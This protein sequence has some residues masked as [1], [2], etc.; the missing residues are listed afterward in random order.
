MRI[1]TKETPSPDELSRWLA[2]SEG[3]LQGLTDVDEKPTRLTGYQL[4]HLRDA[5]KFRAREKAR[6]VGFSFVC[7]AEALAKAHLRRDY[8]AIFV[9]MNLEEAVEKIRYANQLYHSLPLKWQKKKVVDNKTSIEFEDPSGRYRSRLISH[10]CKDPR[11]KHKADVFL[12]EFAHYGHKQ[13]AIYVAAV[14]IVSRGDGQLT[15]GSTPLMVGDLFHEIMKEERRKYPMFT[16]Q[17]VPWWVCPEFCTNVARAKAQAESMETAER[18]HAFGQPTLVDIFHTMERDDFRQ[19]YELSFN[20]ESQTFFPYDL[21]FACCQDELETCDTI[22]SLLKKTEGDLYAGFDVGRTRNTSELIVLEKTAKRVTY[23]MGKSFD[24]SRFQAQ[25]A[26]LR[27]LL[28]AS[29]RIRRLCIDRHGIGMNLAENLRTEYRSRVEGVALVGQVKESLAVDLKIAFESEAVA[30]P[31]TRELTAQI[32][33]IKKTPTEAGYARFD[34]EKN[35][36]HHAD[37]FWAL[38]LAVHAAG[39]GK[40]RRRARERVS[41]SIV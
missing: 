7:A 37:K 5:S 32:H 3:F 12:D 29:P 41:A 15:I 22:D 21:I 28:K 31:R 27:E 38:A 2:T 20:D 16:R 34:T 17:S 13:R 11:G 26:F 4:D 10:P 19:E 25:E 24:R 40:E 36:R 39:L 14:P 6:G 23:R 30:I 33:S 35:E 8:T 9:S 18:V 1:V